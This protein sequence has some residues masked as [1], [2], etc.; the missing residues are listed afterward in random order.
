M[1]E[2]FVL[3]DVSKNPFG[4]L[5][6]KIDHESRIAIVPQAPVGRSHQAIQAVSG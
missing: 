2:E 4:N 6:E 3:V 5:R 1:D